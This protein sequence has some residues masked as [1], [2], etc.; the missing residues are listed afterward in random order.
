MPFLGQ[1]SHFLIFFKKVHKNRIFIS[2]LPNLSL[3]MSFY[4]NLK[5]M[6]NLSHHILKNKKNINLTL[7][8]EKQFQKGFE[9]VAFLA[10]VYIEHTKVHSFYNIIFKSIDE[11]E[12]SKDKVS[13]STV[14]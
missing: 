7:S 5:R 1:N 8:I 13:I 2:K 3:K 12:E 9:K 11:K 10:D 6:H 14:R 4:V